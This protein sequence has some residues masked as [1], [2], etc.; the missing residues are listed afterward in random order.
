MKRPYKKRIKLRGDGYY[1]PQYRWFGMWFDYDL[2]DVRFCTSTSYRYAS[3]AGARRMLASRED[4]ELDK[5]ERTKHA[6]I[7]KWNSMQ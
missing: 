2:V 7:I 6:K 5:I 4:Y 3:E 1:Y